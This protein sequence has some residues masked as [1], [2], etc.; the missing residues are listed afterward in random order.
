MCTEDRIPWLAHVPVHSL[1][2][3]VWSAS[4]AWLIG[5]YV[6]MPDHL[7]LFAAPNPIWEGETSAEPR[8]EPPSFD[9][10]VRYWKSQ[11]T[12]HH[13]NIVHQWQTDHWDRRLRREES[14]ADKSEY[15][16][17]NPVRHGLVS[18]SAL[19]PYRGQLHDLKW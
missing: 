5:H 16:R 13:G 11:F 1:L 9:N 15:V 7:H 8:V 3:E 6:I 17:N 4:D 12:K 10:W 19:W 2:R 14:Y 18:D